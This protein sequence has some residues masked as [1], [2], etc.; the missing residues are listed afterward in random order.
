MLFRSIQT[1]RYEDDR[2]FRRVLDI[3]EQVAGVDVCIA[4]PSMLN[5]GIG[6]SGIAQFTED[7]VFAD[8]EVT[9]CVADPDA[10]NG[11]SVRAFEKAGYVLIATIHVPDRPEVTAV[12]RRD[13][14]APG[15]S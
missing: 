14:P 1:H 11:R 6:S 10:R 7:V 2:E 12:L 9:A 5:R 3:D 8:S 4:E 13:R 15:H